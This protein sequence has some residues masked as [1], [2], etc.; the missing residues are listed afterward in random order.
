MKP[1]GILRVLGLGAFFGLVTYLLPMVG[2]GLGQS[3]NLSL[4]CSNLN[5]C[6]EMK[7]TD[8]G[9]RLQI[10]L[11]LDN[12]QLILMIQILGLYTRTGALFQTH[13]EINLTLL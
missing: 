6:R 8:K 4:N 9:L 7:D 12:S 2:V 11:S 3:Y 1:L 5:L 13:F 10:Y